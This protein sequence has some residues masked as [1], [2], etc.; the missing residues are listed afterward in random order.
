[1]IAQREP[2]SQGDEEKRLVNA[3]Q[4]MYGNL[5]KDKDFPFDVRMRDHYVVYHESIGRTEDGQIF[6]K[7]ATRRYSFFTPQQWEEKYNN[8]NGKDWFTL[9]GKTATVLHDPI[10][11]A[12]E[13][14]REIKG[15][16]SLKTGKSLQEKLAEAM[17]AEQV[18]DNKNI[19][20]D[21][22]KKPVETKPKTR[23]GVSDGK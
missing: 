23:K 19:V 12:M 21:T 16:Y 1:M 3:K 20:E 4:L 14:G 15:Y 2:R 10:K 9:N 7:K 11:Q 8:P 22:E 6:S 13:E 5:D 17:T 18:V